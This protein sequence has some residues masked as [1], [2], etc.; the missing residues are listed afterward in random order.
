MKLTQMT[1]T[2]VSAILMHNPASMR[3]GGAGRGRAWSG[4]V[5][6]GEVW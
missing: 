1:I 4:G 6:H 5:G 2:G 3:R